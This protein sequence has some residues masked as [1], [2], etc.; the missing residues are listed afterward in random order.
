M[1]TTDDIDAT[2]A[3]TRQLISCASVTP[4]DAGCQAI[5]TARLSAVGFNIEPMRFGNVDNFWAT[6]G[7]EG[8]L[9]VFAGH[10][11][12]GPPGDLSIWQSDP[13]IA[14]A[15]GEDLVGRGAAD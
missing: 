14:T 13:F 3:L 1:P 7:E 4:D 9:L 8:P 5:M 2:L 15:S 12:V 11:D 10:T 6:R